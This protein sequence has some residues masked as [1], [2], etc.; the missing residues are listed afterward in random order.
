MEQNLTIL[1]S[2]NTKIPKS[3]KEAKLECIEI[4]KRDSKLK[5]LLVT[6]EFTSLCPVTSQPDFGKIE[7][8]YVPQKYLIESKSL[9][10]YLF[11]Y[12]NIGLFQEEIVET[13]CH[14]LK[15]TLKPQYIK[16]TGTF[17]ARGG[18]EIIASSEWP[19]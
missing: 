19:K 11:G 14:D 8:E 2:K 3:P 13:I 1:G 16:V 12:R 17:K 18:I 5:V 6:N 15:N 7:I 10:L 4:K 9:K